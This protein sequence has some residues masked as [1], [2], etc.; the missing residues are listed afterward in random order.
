MCFIGKHKAH[1]HLP[2]PRFDFIYYTGIKCETGCFTSMRCA[3]TEVTNKMHLRIS[4]HDVSSVLESFG[5]CAVG[6]QNV[7][8]MHAQ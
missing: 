7:H 1:T 2:W 6:W 4:E 5:I 3:V 8:S